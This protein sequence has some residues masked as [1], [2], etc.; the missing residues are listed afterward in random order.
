MDTI[1]SLRVRVQWRKIT[2]ETLQNVQSNVDV[3]TRYRL[4]PSCADC[5][6]KFWEPQPPGAPRA[7]PGR[8]RYTFTTTHA[9]KHHSYYPVPHINFKPTSLSI[10]VGECTYS[11]NTV[12]LTCANLLFWLGRKLYKWVPTCS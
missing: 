5:L 10:I 6:E 7:C 8:Y 1:Y 12:S 11:N 4:P 9:I 2:K 3:V